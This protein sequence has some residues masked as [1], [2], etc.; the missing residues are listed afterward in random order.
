MRYSDMRD[1]RHELSGLLAKKRTGRLQK[2][3][4]A[5]LSTQLETT[6]QPPETPPC[7]NTGQRGDFQGNTY[8][9]HYR[10]SVTARMMRRGTR[11]GRS[12]IQPIRSRIQRTA[13]K[14]RTGGVK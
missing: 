8:A 12:G 1:M 3:R 6:T 7:V 11:F 2:R 14:R 5:E 10:T 9:A 13:R 4:M